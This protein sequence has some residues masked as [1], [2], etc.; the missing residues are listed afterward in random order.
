MSKPRDDRQKGL[1]FDRS[2]MTR[3]RHR[4]G[5]EQLVALI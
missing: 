1:P 3:W 2:S 4:L 5:E